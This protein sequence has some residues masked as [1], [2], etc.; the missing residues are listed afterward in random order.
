M[1]VFPRL[2]RSLIQP[3][4]C[5]SWLPRRNRSKNVAVTEVAVRA[6][7]SG[8]AGWWDLSRVSRAGDSVVASGW[9]SQQTPSEGTSSFHLRMILH[10]LSCKP[11]WHARVSRIHRASLD[12]F[13]HFTVRIQLKGA[14]QVSLACV[15]AEECCNARVL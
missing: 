13:K 3:R 14:A 15:E 11:Y 6:T 4:S 2:S 10:K 5:W 1:L 7:G 12:G 8:P 9:K